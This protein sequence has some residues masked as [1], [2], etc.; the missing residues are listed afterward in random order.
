MNKFKVGD[1]VIRTKDSWEGMNPGNIAIVTEITGDIGVKLQ[2]YEK[3]HSS[4]C[5][6]LASTES[7]AQV[8]PTGSLRYNAGKLPLHLVPPSAIEA[9]AEVLQ[10][11]ATK[12]SERN[13]EKGN[14]LSV[15]YAS[16]MRHLLAFWSG[17]ETDPE[18]GLPHLNHVLMNAAMLVEYSKK[19]EFDDRPGK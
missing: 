3:V 17:E 6:E 10:Y 7:S 16:L 13:W 1:K 4:L 12:Y 5:L 18:S 15:P 9:M 19:Q 2:G 8:S 11:G 14:Y